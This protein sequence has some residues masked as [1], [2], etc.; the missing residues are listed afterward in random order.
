M[1]A[2]TNYL[3]NSILNLVLRN[4]TFPAIAAVYVQLHTADP[5]ETGT[6][7]PLASCPR[8]AMTFAAAASATAANDAT[9]SVVTS[10][11]GMI[12]HMSLWDASA[13]GN[14][15]LYGTLGTSKAVNAGDTINLA[16]GV[17]KVNAS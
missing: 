6:A 12:T 3:E 16:S 9:G 13:A 15:L 5:G 1:T 14:A 7:N 10:A 17:L 11:S 4:T 8:F 2:M